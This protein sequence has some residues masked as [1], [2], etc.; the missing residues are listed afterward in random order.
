M[1]F[2]KLVFLEVDNL[3]YELFLSRTVIV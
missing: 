3:D 2:E 1:D